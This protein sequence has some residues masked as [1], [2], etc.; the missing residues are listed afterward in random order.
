MATAKPA[1]AGAAK[2]R[3]S[4][5]KLRAANGGGLGAI[6]KQKVA[7]RLLGSNKDWGWGVGVVANGTPSTLGIESVAMGLPNRCIWA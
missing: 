2:A 3:P 4:Q 5:T 1:G 7:S 6:G